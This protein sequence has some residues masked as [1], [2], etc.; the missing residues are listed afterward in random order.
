MACRLI[1]KGV[2]KIFIKQNS[3]LAKMAAKRMGFSR[4]AIVIGR[5]IH[6]HNTTVQDF[7]K[8]KKW[9]LHE[10]K[11]VEQYERGLLRFIKDYL[12]EY[13]RNGYYQNKYEVEA[14]AAEDD[15]GLLEKYD[16]SLYIML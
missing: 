9:L 2:K 7:I 8:N 13:R 1:C 15:H 16:I 3:W 12:V 6:L 4:I 11:H 10:L 14:R 5:K